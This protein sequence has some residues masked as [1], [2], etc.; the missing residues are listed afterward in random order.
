MHT[1]TF[2][3]KLTVAVASFAAV[4]FAQAQTFEVDNIQYEVTD[5]QG[6]I[7]KVANGSNAAGEV[8]IPLRV[9]YGGSDYTVTEVA[10]YAFR[11]NE[12]ITGI[13][14]P[15]TVMKIGIM[16]FARCNQLSAVNISEGLVEIGQNAFENCLSLQRITLPESL[17]TLGRRAFLY[18]NALI[19]INV[20]ANNANFTSVDGVLF[21][22]DKKTLLRYP[23]SKNNDGAYTIPEGVEILDIASLEGALF[24]SV[25]MPSTLKEIREASFLSAIRLTT[26]NI[27]NGVTTIGA[28]AFASC[29]RM[30]SI[31]IPASVTS[32]A[33]EAF[34]YTIMLTGIYVDEANQSYSSLDGVL[35]NKDKTELV[36]FLTTKSGAYVFPS[37]VQ[38][39]RNG[40]FAD[41]NRIESIELPASLT[42]IGRNAFFSCSGLKTI[43]IHATVPPTVGRQ[44]FDNIPTS[45]VVLKVPVGTSSLY[46]TA[47]QWRLFLIQ[48]DATLSAQDVVKVEDTRVYPNP[49]S[50]EFSIHT[51]TATEATVV[52]A[53]GQVVK[54]LSLSKGDNKVDI[55]KQPVGLYIVKVGDKTF[56]VLKK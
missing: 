37:T 56:K 28:N 45:A 48:E 9:S 26:V 41:A 17:T 18:C 40:A 13:T 12:S 46:R 30:Q 47:D 7:V 24:Q 6:L 14:L 29:L 35:F 25:T 44:A 53:V 52:N 20:N 55:S 1:F 51:T 39:V 5:A 16:A 21:T 43:L 2:S 34:K 42:Q 3:K 23:S 49:T 33:D 36:K 19:S 50:G 31:Y 38:R 10:D 4:V 8:T 22:K 11:D 27:P 54:S 32:I 15:E